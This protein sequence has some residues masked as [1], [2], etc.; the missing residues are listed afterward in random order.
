MIV[1]A[2]IVEMLFQYFH[3]FIRIEGQ[4]LH[5]ILILHLYMS[6]RESG[7]SREVHSTRAKQFSLS[8]SPDLDVTRGS[9]LTQLAMAL[10]RN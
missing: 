4:T 5:L 3:N 6:V 7:R 2:H 10:A 8:S 1:C 9:P